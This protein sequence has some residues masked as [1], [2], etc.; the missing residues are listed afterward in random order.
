MVLKASALAWKC[1]SNGDGVCFI[2]G[3]LEKKKK[4]LVYWKPERN[5]SD[6][7]AFENTTEFPHHG[8]LRD[9]GM[10]ACTVVQSYG[11]RPTAT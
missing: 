11:D 6:Y 5:V 8:V 9:E 3:L 2:H 7:Y 1:I 10:T 4:S